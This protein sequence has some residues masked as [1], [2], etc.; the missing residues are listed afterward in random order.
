MKEI[1]AVQIFP[2]LT[3][4]GDYCWVV[5]NSITFMSVYKAPNNPAAIQPLV[6]WSPPPMS[7]VVGDFNSVHWAWQPSANKSYGQGD[8]MENWAK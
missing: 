8:E 1:D 2:S 3:L 5:V 6:S 4:T 7:V